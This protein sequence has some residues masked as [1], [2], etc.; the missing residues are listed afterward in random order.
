M[1]SPIGRRLEAIEKRMKDAASKTLRVV[2]QRIDTEGK[3]E[4]DLHITIRPGCSPESIR[5][6]PG[7]SADAFNHRANTKQTCP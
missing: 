7:E 2:V 3:A 4:P 6:N 1:Q 5:R